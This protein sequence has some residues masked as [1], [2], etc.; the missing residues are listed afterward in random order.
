MFDKLY[1]LAK[2]GICIYSGPPQDLNKHLN[3]CD[4]NCT[5]FQ[6]PIKVLLKYACNGFENKYVI[7]MAE[8]ALQ[9]KEMLLSKCAEEAKLFPN[10]IQFIAKR[11]K[12]IDFWYLLLRTMTITYRYKW[13]LVLFQIITYQIFGFWL[14][15][16]FG[17]D[18]GKPSGCISFE[19]DF[20]SICNKTID[21]LEDELL[22]YNNMKY[23][24]LLI[25][26]LTYLQI[27]VATLTFT[28][29]L[30]IFLNEHRNGLINFFF[31]SKSHSFYS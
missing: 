4:I 14:S 21:Q 15:L 16:F 23:N 5:E 29:D 10:G 18:I 25:I 24:F 6:V 30:K 3:E 27:V 13:K 7:K 1:V 26:Q 17:A 2:G 31:F 9:E 11:F 22:L 28:L 20:N 8:K 19:D 12:L